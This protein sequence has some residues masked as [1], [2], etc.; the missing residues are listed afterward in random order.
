MFI[1]A[2][3]GIMFGTYVCAP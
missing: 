1:M 2:I 3:A